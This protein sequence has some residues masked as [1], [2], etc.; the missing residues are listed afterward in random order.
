[1]QSINLLEELNS[2]SK[3]HSLKRDDIDKLML[4]F[5]ER[6][7]KT[8]KIERMS[9]WLFNEDKT[10][11]V[12][13]GE[14]TRPT[15]KFTKETKLNKTN[16]PTY[17]KS[18]CVN[19]I[20][21]VENVYNNSITK[22]LKLDYCLKNKVISL[23]DIPLRIEG[24]V[25]GVLCFEKTGKKERV[26]D[27]TEKTFALSLAI[28]LAS[29]LE[30]RQRRA[31]QYKLDQEL[32][33]KELLIKEIHHRVKNNLT[34]IASLLN[35]QMDKTKD[36]YHSDLFE[37]H[38]SKIDSIAVIH[39]L[40]YKSKN[41]TEISLRDYIKKITS[42]LQEVYKSE[43]NKIQ[44]AHDVHE[45]AVDLSYALPIGLII[46][47]VITN[48][49]KHAFKGRSSGQIHIHLNIEKRKVQLS[50]SDDGQGLSQQSKKAQSIGMDILAGLVEQID[51][52]YSL[53]SQ[54][55]TVFTL[56]FDL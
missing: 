19:E 16:Y 10:E 20:V 53:N 2:I 56:E 44:I 49:F 45:V 37:D 22:E 51:G 28:V 32:K 30:A 27:K 39:E 25:V 8:L 24:K 21:D 26:F 29:N 40:V 50:I 38:R 9:V 33:Q 5:A 14:Y 47:E 55:G 34:I 52:K 1:M 3:I 36:K 31:I 54:Q 7:T 48:S 4:V 11:I 42:N 46:N 12:S 41:Y 17:F 6:I 13:I 43:Q 15:K 23:M 18:I 35:M